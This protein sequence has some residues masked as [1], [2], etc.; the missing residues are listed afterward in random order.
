MAGKVARPRL[1]AHQGVRRSTPA[2]L[3]RPATL[4]T[5]QRLPQGY[6]HPNTS[7]TWSTSPQSRPIKPTA[8]RC[9][10][11]GNKFSFCN[12]AWGALFTAGKI[13]TRD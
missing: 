10:L 11:M 7:A 3:P 13:L 9:N 2:T 8:M 4:H 12:T 1:V 6:D 5:T